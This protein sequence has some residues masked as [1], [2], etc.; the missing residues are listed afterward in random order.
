MEAGFGGSQH[1]STASQR[2]KI[3]CIESRIRHSEARE[4]QCKG[5]SPNAFPVAK[6]PLYLGYPQKNSMLKREKFSTQNLNQKNASPKNGGWNMKNNFI[7]KSWSQMVGDTARTARNA[8][9]AENTAAAPAFPPDVFPHSFPR[10]AWCFWARNTWQTL[11][12]N[13]PHQGRNPA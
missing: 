4:S 11:N 2:T 10:K 7:R 12:C 3:Q 1:P 5:C 8:K 6:H 13:M 9:A